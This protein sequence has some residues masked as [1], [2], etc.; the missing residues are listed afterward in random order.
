MIA[1]LPISLADAL[2]HEIAAQ[3]AAAVRAAAESLSRAYRGGAAPAALSPAAR[4]AYLAVRFPATFAVAQTVWRDVLRAAPA[5]RSVLDAGAGPAT[6]SLAAHD[7][8]DAGTHYTCL[9]RDAGWGT[10]AAALARACGQRQTF[11]HGT[12]GSDAGTHDAAI[13]CYSLSELDPGERIGAVDALWR[14]SR[15]ALIVIEPGTPAGFA[16]VRAA[17]ERVLAAGGH[18]AA[19]CP[20]DG[21]CPMSADDWCHR[22]VRVAR[23]ALHRAAKQAA[24]GFEDEKFSYV[25]LTRRVPA[26]RGAGRVVRKPMKNAGHVH[27]DL[28]TEAGLVRETVTR[29]D[30]ASYRE[31]RDVEWGGVWPPPAR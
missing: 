25:V 11:R 5:I 29:S 3:P 2:A 8:L 17:R 6:A 9:E 30:K 27:L 22:P 13:A 26:W 20:H 18:A 7:V 12:I 21:P 28:C 24:L 4:A 16:V 23:S 15:A 1:T 14:A 19:P 31:A 10:T